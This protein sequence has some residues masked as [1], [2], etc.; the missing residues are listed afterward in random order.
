MRRAR[1][2][3]AVA[4]AVLTLA[5]LTGACGER[6]DDRDRL[7]AALRRTKAMSRTFTYRE[8]AAGQQISVEGIVEDDFRYAGRLNLDGEPLF[9]QVVA[10]DAL[11]FRMLATEQ[12]PPTAITGSPDADQAL[13]TQ[14]WVVDPQG[15]PALTSAKKR[16][17]PVGGR[18]V[19]AE[20]YA[21]LTAVEVSVTE[22]LVV[23]KYSEE[24]LYYKPSE[25]PFPTPDEDS[26][27]TRYDLERPRLPRASEGGGAGAAQR[28]PAARHF[29]KL[30]IYVKDGLVQRVLERVAFDER[31]DDTLDYL[32]ST[33]PEGDDTISSFVKKARGDLADGRRSSVEQ[34]VL[35]GLNVSRET[36]GED[37]IEFRNLEVLFR[38]FDADRPVEIPS[39][40]VEAA[41]TTLFKI[42]EEDVADGGAGATGSVQTDGTTTT[43]STSTPAPPPS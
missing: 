6:V 14:A 34:A 28:L 25:D 40:P 23:R 27:I 39:A 33:A 7:V 11:G 29:R 19:L 5:G 30:S 4:L 22:S 10:D 2:V 42:V 38:D 13:R 24:A 36:F 8:E 31:L 43:T 16:S 41:L 1:R 3:T 37:P 20:A 12:L 21:Y 26:G 15:A 18:D 35:A 17:G 32:E 9:E